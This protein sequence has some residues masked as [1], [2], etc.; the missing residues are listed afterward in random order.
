MMISHSVVFTKS[1]KIA[2]F[3][4]NKFFP[5]DFYYYCTFLFVIVLNKQ[6]QRLASH[7]FNEQFRE[8][9]SQITTF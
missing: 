3:H 5:K 9:A 7:F 1:M 2:I 4:E 8:L 6:F